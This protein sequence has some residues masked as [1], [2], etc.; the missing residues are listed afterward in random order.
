MFFGLF[1]NSKRGSGQTKLF[2]FRI[3]TLDQVHY[4]A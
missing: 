2:K 4:D 1:L 3:T